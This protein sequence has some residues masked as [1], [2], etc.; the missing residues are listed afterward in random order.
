MPD[1]CFF[2]MQF[3][4]LSLVSSVFLLKTFVS[5]DPSAFFASS[6]STNPNSQV[7]CLAG[8]FP[9]TVD[10]NLTK[11]TLTEPKNQ[12]EASQ[13]LVNLL[14]VN[15]NAYVNSVTAGS[16]I[17]HGTYSIYAKFCAPA[18]NKQFQNVQTLQVLSHGDTLSRTYWDLPPPAPSFVDYMTSQGYATLAYDRLGIGLSDHPD[19]INVVQYP[20]H[21]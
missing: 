16:Q 6:E 2:K 5:A 20:I 7:A 15:S 8:Y 1:S 19:A 12:Y 18:K 10:V 11:F 9:V 4:L 13:I 3:T 17:V 14:G 21:I